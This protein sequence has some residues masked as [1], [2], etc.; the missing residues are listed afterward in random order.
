MM[1]IC[2][3]CNHEAEHEARGLC[4]NCYQLLQKYHRLEEYPDRRAAFRAMYQ[5]WKEGRHAS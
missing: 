2:P 1:I 3:R 5:E 4:R